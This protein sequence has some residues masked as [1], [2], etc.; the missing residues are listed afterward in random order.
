MHRRKWRDNNGANFGCIVQPVYRTTNH[1]L[2]VRAV[3]KR[4]PHKIAKNWLTPPPL[5]ALVQPPLLCPCG[6]NINFEV[7]EVFCTKTCGRPHLKNHLLSAICPRWSSPPPIWLQTPFLENLLSLFVTIGY[8]RTKSLSRSDMFTAIVKLQ[9]KFITLYESC[10]KNTN[11][12]RVNVTVSLCFKSRF[13]L[14]S[15]L[16]KMAALFLLLNRFN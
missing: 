8:L 5:S 11:T 3:H 7:S 1:I 12:S 13:I 14:T 4:R 16:I 9:R 10:K 2:C 6:H 15:I